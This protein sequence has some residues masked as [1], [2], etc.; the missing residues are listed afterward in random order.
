M[1]FRVALEPHPQARADDPPGLTSWQRR[2]R[3]IRSHG[4]RRSIR[5]AELPISRRVDPR[6]P[7]IERS[8][9]GSGNLGG[10]RQST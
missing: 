8:A 1:N 9:R 7:L 2:Q 6:C 3:Q 10:C 5:H 4:R